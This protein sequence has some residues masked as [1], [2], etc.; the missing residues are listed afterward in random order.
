VRRKRIFIVLA[1]FALVGIGVVAFWPGERE[2]E[3]NGKKL[4]EWL[5][6]YEL[7]Y[8]NESD[9]RLVERDQ[10]AAAD[11]IQHIGTNALPWLLKR[12][13][14]NPPAWKQKMAPFTARIPSRMLAHWYT[15]GERLGWD[16]LQGFR[17]LGSRAAP[18]VPELA[19][20]I[21]NGTR[22]GVGRDWPMNA[23]SYIGRD[24]FPALLAALGNP[25]TEFQAAMCI[26]EMAE[27]G[28]DVS[29]AIPALLLIDHAEDYA[30]K[31]GEANPGSRE[32][33]YAFVLPRLTF[34]KRQPSLIPA[35]TN[36]LQHTNNDVRVEAAKA[37]GRIGAEARQ[38]VPALREAL[39]V[40]VVAVQEAAINALERIAPEVLTNGVKDF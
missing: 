31:R 33:D 23:L 3:Y 4:S 30:R 24:G 37:L 36:C 40:R 26:C 6:A 34:E 29:Q 35:L 9:R 11:A 27:H 2:P 17:V 21:K 16:A 25:K 8:S 10:A 18:A 39:E 32:V 38:A 15:E 13:A 7:G 19:Q 5:R 12:I 1:L 22:R 28:V 20:M 14:Y